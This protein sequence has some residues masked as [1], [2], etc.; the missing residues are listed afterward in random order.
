MKK[1]L[2]GLLTLLVLISPANATAPTLPDYSG[3]ILTPAPSITP[4][5]TGPRIFGVRPG[6]PILHRL[7]AT[8]EK[9]MRF[10]ATG[11]PSGVFLHEDTGSLTGRL[12]SPG[13]HR[14]NVSATNRHGAAT[15]EFRLVVGEAISLTPP[16]GWNS[17]NCFYDKPDQTGILATAH[18]MVSTGLA[19]HGWSYI[20]IDDG[21]QGQRSGPLNALQ[22]SERFHDMKKLA[23]GV[24][25]LGLK[26]GIYSSPWVTSY[27]GYAGGSSD[28]PDGA[29]QFPA[30][31]QRSD[32]R[33]GAHVFDASD[34]A[35]WAAWGIDYVKYDWNPLE[36]PETKRMHEALRA[37]GRDMIFSISNGAN[38]YHRESFPK[39]CHVW[40]TSNDLDDKWSSIERI[41]SIHAPW[42]PYS[43]P[44]RWADPDM[45]I[46]GIVG[47]KE[48]PHPTHLTP[49]EQFTH[50]SL[51]S[52]WAAPL[53][54]SCPLDKLD[55]FTLSL[56]TNA[57][58]LD[59]NQDT[60]GRQAV[61]VAKDGALE[62]WAKPLADGGHAIGLFN[63]GETTGSVSIAWRQLG[64][65][66]PQHVRD[67]WR[68]KNLGVF[69]EKFS[70]EVRP[71]GVVLIT[72]RSEIP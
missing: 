2:L 41:W 52:L 60:L 68:Q 53:L 48:G 20:N 23:D 37:S 24:H 49:D 3:H 34:A 45:L 50:I 36:I 59:I 35:Q 28:T 1:R 22:P 51:W 11:L 31:G 58:V 55:P 63:R 8:G 54:I 13:E 19:D 43:G 33:F 57:E 72:V 25:A 56:L 5:L 39:V 21:W 42:A 27:A 18:S 15:R 9:P 6:H 62:A 29:W 32:R 71:H 40:R 17:W 7:S 69:T 65:T 46:V 38:I 67:A 10:T 64:E 12:G 4:R 47:W 14:I 70:A 61:L 30:K 26:L 16:L 66:K 44:G